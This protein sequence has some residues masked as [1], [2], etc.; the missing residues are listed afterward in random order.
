LLI[1]LAK[2]AY[3]AY[4]FAEMALPVWPSENNNSP[5][6]IGQVIRSLREEKGWVQEELAHEAGVGTSFVS[7]IERGDRQLTINKLSALA[8]ALGTSV[9]AICAQTEGLP[10]PTASD[11]QTGDLTLDHT[12]EAV[13]LRKA[14]RKLSL[15]SRR[16][17]VDFAQ[18]LAKQPVI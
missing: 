1:E 2:L 6:Q 16:L 12:K 11:G 13:E 5:M 14:F 3:Q 18:M 15:P 8:A 4:Q 9:T 10:V 7:R 17:V